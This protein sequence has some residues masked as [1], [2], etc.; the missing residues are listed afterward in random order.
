[1]IKYAGHENKENNP[2]T[3][4][5]L[6]FNQILPRSPDEIYGESEENMHVDIGA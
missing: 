4:N 6:I 5:V 1:M 2:Q 3:G